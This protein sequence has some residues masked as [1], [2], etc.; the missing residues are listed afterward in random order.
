[1][2]LF[3]QWSFTAKGKQIRNSVSQIWNMKEKFFLLFF[4]SF[5][6]TL[7][8][9]SH[10]IVNAKYGETNLNVLQHCTAN[11]GY[12]FRCLKPIYQCCS[13][14][15]TCCLVFKISQ[16]TEQPNSRTTAKYAHIYLVWPCFAFSELKTITGH[17]LLLKWLCL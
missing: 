15:I 11:V 7:L 6:Q 17:I 4:M 13:L 14:S 5:W 8:Q 2:F 1:M 10:T 3:F 9:L 16:I 12:D